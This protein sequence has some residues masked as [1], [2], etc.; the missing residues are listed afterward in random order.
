MR[1]AVSSL[2]WGAGGL[3]LLACAVWAL[4]WA[5]WR[6]RRQERAL[7]SQ[8]LHGTPYR[9]LRGDLKEDARLLAEARSKPMPLSHHIIHRVA[10]L[11]HAAMSEF[12]T[13]VLSYEGEKWAKH[14]RI[15]NPAFHLEKLKRM[16]PAFS[17]CCSDLVSRWE[18]LVGPEGSCE[19]DVWPELQNFTGDVISRAAFGSS[20]EEGRRIFELQ[21]EIAELIIQTGKTAVYVPG[22]RSAP[23]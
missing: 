1:S 5:W 14:R 17:V 3:L 23:L 19:F 8:G 4:N 21:A 2:G 7:R 11:L 12:A 16:L 15:L 22:Y 6:P 18:K 10:P 13:G 20:Y 9:L